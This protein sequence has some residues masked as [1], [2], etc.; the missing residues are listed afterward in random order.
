MPGQPE[1]AEGVG[2]FLTMHLALPYHCDQ[3]RLAWIPVSSFI[4]H[5]K[6]KDSPLALTSPGFL[7]GPMA[8]D[9]QQTHSIPHVFEV[10]S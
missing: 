3:G 4:P 7:R 1:A 10:S 2:S 6:G 5:I 9:P 8:L